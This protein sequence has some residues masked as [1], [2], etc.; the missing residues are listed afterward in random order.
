LLTFERYHW[1]HHGPRVAGVDEAGRGPLAGPVMAAAVILDPSLAETEEQGALRGLTDSKKL[2]RSHR[3]AFYE[4]LLGAP[5]IEIG[6]GCAEVEEIDRLNILQATHAAM[7]RAVAALPAPP[8]FTLVDGRPVPELG[9]ACRAIVSG[10]S[11]S[12]SI[13]AASVIAKV[14]RD[15]HMRELARTYPQYGFD[16]HKGY[17]TAAH[18]QALFEYGPSPVHRMSFR[19]VREAA[20]IR[21][22]Q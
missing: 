17:G 6:I 4:V 12:L 1:G 15:A 11:Q 13:A 9:G 2:T 19:P 18:V 8:D 3:E 21:R 10:D 20:A 16:K 5:G 22:G 7:A 14:V